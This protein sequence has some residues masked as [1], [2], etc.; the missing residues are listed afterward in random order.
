MTLVEMDQDAP[1]HNLEMSCQT[2]ALT[3]HQA[4]YIIHYGGQRL[5]TK[6]P[7]C[8]ISKIFYISYREHY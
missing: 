2:G 5:E 3:D 4:P 6:H 7:K 8:F 1:A